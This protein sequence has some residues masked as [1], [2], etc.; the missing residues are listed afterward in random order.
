VRILRGIVGEFTAFARPP[1][2]DRAPHDLAA[3]LADVVRPYQG[4]LP[5][6]VSLTL[7]C[8]VPGPTVIAD[9]RLLERAV[10]NLVE[11]ALQAVGEHGR[12]AVRLT[13][14]DG[15][16]SV[17]VEDDGPGIEP[18]LRERV[19]EPFF[20]TKTGGSGLGLALVRKIAQQHGGGVALDSAPGKG[21]R[22]VLW[23]PL[24]TAA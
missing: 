18:E 15:R 5:R 3:I 7:D 10:V 6:G 9:R 17:E 12:V 24:E 19:F 2:F 13:S 21:T 8:A 23:L 4:A 16:A 1:Q 14:G 22:C 20:S 11:N